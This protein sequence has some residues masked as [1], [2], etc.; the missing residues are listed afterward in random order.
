MAIPYTYSGSLFSRPS[1]KGN[2]QQQ[3]DKRGS[4]LQQIDTQPEQAQQDS[5]RHFQSTQKTAYEVTVIGVSPIPDKQHRYIV[6]G[7]YKKRDT[8]ETE[9]VAVRIND[10]TLMLNSEGAHIPPTAIWELQE[11]EKIVVEGDKTK[12]GVIRASCVSFSR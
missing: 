10:H 6:A 9:V 12:R 3:V 1:S 2:S 11:G 8:D 5:Q 7:S 4:T